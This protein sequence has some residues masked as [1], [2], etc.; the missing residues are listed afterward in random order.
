MISYISPSTDPAWNLALEEYFFDTVPAGESFFMLWQNHNTVVIGKNQN[1]LAEIDQDY[2]RS[3]GITVVRRLSGGGAVYHDDGN[4]NFTFIT[5]APEGNQIDLRRF[6][7]PV[8]EALRA[9]G[10]DAEVSGRNDITVD[11]KKFSG[12]A[13]Y[14]RHGRVMHH[15]TLMFDSDMHILQQVLKADP[16][17][18]ASKGIQ[19]VSSRVTNLKPYLPTGV[20]CA[21]FMERLMEAMTGSRTPTVTELSAEALA[22]V[23]K[24]KDDRYGTWQWNYGYSPAC[25]VTSG[26]RI[27]GCGSVRLQFSVTEGRLRDLRISG[28]FF[29]NRDVSELAEILEGCENRADAVLQ[30]LQDLPLESYIHRLTVSDLVE[31]LMA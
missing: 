21:E 26:K 12:N 24:R 13:Q 10:V 1:T 23:Q 30:R 8:A 31:L 18:I 5:D 2:V 6:C 25:T 15:G 20:G 7:L 28:D 4:I 29:G 14:V 11:G 27:D 9:F 19:S 16:E 17:K 22:S 3:H